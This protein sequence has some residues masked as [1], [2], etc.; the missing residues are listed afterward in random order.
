[1]NPNE[2]KIIRSRGLGGLFIQLD[3]SQIYPN[4]PGR[5]CPALVYRGGC[6][7]TFCCASNEG[8]LSNDESGDTERLGVD[9]LAWLDSVEAD[10]QNFISRHSAAKLAA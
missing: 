9:D 10:V 4:D 3:A 5:G 1:M 8:E 7:A 6:S 2:T